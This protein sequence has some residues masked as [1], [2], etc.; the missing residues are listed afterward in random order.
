MTARTE[1]IPLA[2]VKPSLH[3][4]IKVS[5]GMVIRA[6]LFEI[7]DKADTPMTLTDLLRCV[8]EA[9]GADINKE[10]LCVKINRMVEK[11]E[12]VKIKRGLYHLATPTEEDQ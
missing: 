9:Y 12:L 4:W 7:L 1:H 8:N 11:G 6:A 5:D 2:H 3:K 10:G